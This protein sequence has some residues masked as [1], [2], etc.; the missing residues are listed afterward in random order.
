M[1]QTG[2]AWKA[3][4]PLVVC[5]G[6]GEAPPI[7]AARWNAKSRLSTAGARNAPKRT[8]RDDTRNAHIHGACCAR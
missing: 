4:Q 1:V 5:G 7:V 6:G 8:P 2:G 3:P